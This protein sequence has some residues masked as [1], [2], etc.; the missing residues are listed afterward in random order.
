MQCIINKSV[1]NAFDIVNFITNKQIFKHIKIAK[2]TQA[3]L[4][5]E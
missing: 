1:Y 4:W 5:R 3:D 2:G